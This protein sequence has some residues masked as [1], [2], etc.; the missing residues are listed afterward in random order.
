[1]PGMTG[2]MLAKKTMEI[3]PH[4]PVILY[5]GYRALANSSEIAKSGI[6]AF[7]TK[8]IILEDLAATIR[9]V[10]EDAKDRKS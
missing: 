8:P 9:E 4:V 2:L 3:R 6:K 1:M 7:L 5:S 10:L